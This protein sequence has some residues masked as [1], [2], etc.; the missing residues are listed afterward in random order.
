MCNLCAAQLPSYNSKPAAAPA[1][2]SARPESNGTFSAYISKELNLRAG[3]RVTLVCHYGF[4]PHSR[5]LLPRSSPSA[6]AIFL[7]EAQ[8]K[9]KINDDWKLTPEN[10]NALPDPMQAANKNPGGL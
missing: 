2:A 3:R 10:I 5:S 1:I 7:G 6:G 8:G 9:S 4:A